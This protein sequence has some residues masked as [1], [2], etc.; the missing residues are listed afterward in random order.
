M[1]D[2]TKIEVKRDASELFGNIE[3]PYYAYN[4][5]DNPDI[6]GTAEQDYKN[7]WGALIPVL[8]INDIHIQEQDIIELTLSSRNELPTLKCT[9]R[10]SRNLLVKFNQPKAVNTIKV[11]I[12]PQFEGVY[13]KIKLEFFMSTI[14]E[15][16]EGI[17]YCEGIYKLNYLYN[18]LI[19]TYG[20]LTTDEFLDKVSEEG[21]L[22]FATHIKYNLDDKHYR[23]LNNINPITAFNRDISFSGSQETQIYDWFIDFW[24]NVNLIDYYI[25][26]NNL[27]QEQQMCTIPAL[28]ANVTTPN[29]GTTGE[30]NKEA[31]DFQKVPMIY[32]NSQ[33]MQMSPLFINNF[34]LQSLPGLSLFEGSEK[35]YLYSNE[36]NF[37]HEMEAFD[38]IL[39]D[40]K[41]DKD[42]IHKSVFLGR[43]FEEIPILKQ[44][45][46]RNA[47][48][49]KLKT[50]ILV[51]HA[52]K[53]CFGVLRGGKLDIQIYENDNLNRAYMTEN[54]GRVKNDDT[55]Y[56]DYSQE[57][58]V[59]KADNAYILNKYLSGQY[60]VI[61]VDI[62]YKDGQMGASYYLTRNELDTKY[63]EKE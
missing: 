52:A 46:Q 48:L 2:V 1:A 13:K 42:K 29:E 27:T 20:E 55:M 38:I 24:N 26:L 53:Y 51:I 25:Q 10:D 61:G 4:K 9:F 18:D 49:Q 31:K 40:I 15:Y 28:N 57:E 43:E 58:D 32:T 12:I 3:I 63:F 36:V 50:N 14:S 39:K 7:V 54:E 35:E 8:I 59:K 44:K 19:K 5:E 56:G 21:G 41:E 33:G 37:N 34:E 47:Y 62:E 60:T 16:S 30:A 22:G 45:V 17:V 6:H 23:F 11:V